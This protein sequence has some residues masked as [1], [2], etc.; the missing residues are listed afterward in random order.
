[1]NKPNTILYAATTSSHIYHFMLPFI[2]YMN[3]LGYEVD[4]LASQDH[5]SHKL[6][7]NPSIRK[8]HTMDLS[9]SPFSLE[10]YKAY[11][12]IKKLLKEQNYKI[13]HTNTPVV[14]F[15][16]RLASIGLKETKIVYMAHGFHF[17]KGAP[18]KNWLVYFPAEWLASYLTDELIT[19]NQEDYCI[20]KRCFKRC[21]VHYLPS[22]GLDLQKY[23]PQTTEKENSNIIICISE[24]IKRK[25]HKQIIE[26]LPYIMYYINDVTVWFV[27]TGILVDETKAM[28]KKLGVYNHIKWLGFRYDVPELLN[29]ADLAV[30]TSYHEGVP[31]C[32]LEAMACSKPIVATDVRGNRELI[33]NRVNG[34]TVK[35]D[36]YMDFADACVNVLS[37]ENIQKMGG[38]EAENYL[39]NIILIV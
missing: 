30:L 21:N 35:P 5:T 27:G 15:Y 29:Q 22:T 12:S 38:G 8:L 34:Y 1:M 18:L 20:A 6:L 26:A 19:I 10:N 7:E 31:R 16:I 37:S 32:L 25:N 9:R 3:K 13:I 2:E 39:K 23:S 17:Y 14:S 4:V 24:F 33:V 28:A 11:K 36:D